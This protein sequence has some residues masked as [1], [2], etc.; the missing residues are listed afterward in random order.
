MRFYRL[1][2]A[3]LLA[4]IVGLCFCP[5][6]AARAAGPIDFNRQIRPLLADRCFACHGPDES[7]RDSALRLDTRE[8]ALA[9][10]EGHHAITPGKPDESE[11]VRRIS[12]QDPDLRM[13]P[14]D[15]NKQLS[16]EEIELI[17][18]WV[19]QGANW[20]EHWAYRLP[21]RKPVPSGAP[22]G[23]PIDGFILARL[24][25]LDLQP[26]SPADRATLVRRLYLDLTGLPPSAAQVEAFVNDQ[27]P[28]PT[29]GWSISYWRRFITASE[30]PSIGSIWSAMP[31]AAAITAITRGM[32]GCIAIT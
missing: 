8:G 21:E 14:A 4:V 23:N 22:S 1:C 6:G 19:A 11:L 26:A 29:S 7:K 27:A 13:P 2:P 17:R 31:T 24:R 15:S 9:E 18:A 5:T 28:M 20:Q 16:A 32:S 25:D 30:W 3:P 10:I 12:S